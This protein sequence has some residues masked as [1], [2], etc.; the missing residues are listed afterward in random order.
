VTFAVIGFIAGTIGMAI[1]VVLAF[2]SLA[3]YNE[4]RS[5]GQEPPG[6]GCEV[7]GAET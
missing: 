1:V 6:P 5:R 7:P 4:A 2:R 3:E